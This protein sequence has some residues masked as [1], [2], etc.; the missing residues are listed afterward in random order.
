MRDLAPKQPPS[1]KPPSSALL[2]SRTTQ[3]E[4]EHDAHPVLH[5]QRAVGN[6]AVQRLLRTDGQAGGI[7]A[8]DEVPG[9]PVPA[10]EKPPSPEVAER[11]ARN[12]YPKNPHAAELQ[13]KMILGTITPGELSELRGIA[14]FPDNPRAAALYAKQDAGTITPPEQE[15]L[16]GYFSQLASQRRA[17]DGSPGGGRE[18]PRAAALRTKQGAGTLSPEELAELQGLNGYPDNPRAAALAKKRTLGTI[19][20][21]E[22]AELQGFDSYPNNRRAAA[23]T[24]KS[25]LGKL[26]PEEQAELQGISGYP[27]NPHAAALAAK[28]TLGTITPDEKAELQGVDLHPYNPRA[29]MLHGRQLRGEKLTRDEELEIIK[30]DTTQAFGEFL[31]RLERKNQQGRLH[32]RENGYLSQEYESYEYLRRDPQV[33]KRAAEILRSGRYVRS[34][35][36]D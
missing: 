25:I 35:F 20:K 28:R 23:L 33:V 31:I 12:A 30:D 19:T 15:E 11:Q 4:T 9:T 6:R 2:R 24:T 8:R 22:Q 26:T 36:D 5:L 27:D 34:A 17:D 10:A 16:R 18:N 13:K 3:P 1:H 14:S 29:A 32:P 21:E 7:I